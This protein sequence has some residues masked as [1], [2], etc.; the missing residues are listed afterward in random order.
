MDL[1]QLKTFLRMAQVKHIGLTADELYVSQSTVN[2]RIRALEEELGCELFARNGRGLQLTAKGDLFQKY[3]ERALEILEEGS[4]RIKREK[5]GFRGCL[6][7]GAVNAAAS[8]L[9]PG[10][11][12]SFRGEYPAVEVEVTTGSTSEI[13]DW[14]LNGKVELG[15]VR[16]P[17]QY[18]GVESVTILSEPILLIIP[19][20]HPWTCRKYATPADFQGQ[21]ILASNRASSIWLEIMNWFKTNDVIPHVGME[22]DHIE[23]AKQM[24]HYGY[25]IAFVPSTSVEKELAEGRVKTVSLKPPFSLCRDTILIRHRR[26]PL[27]DYAEYFWQYLKESRHHRKREGEEK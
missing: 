26:K 8:Y 17:L 14:V 15:L 1:E 10:F 5:A 21:T 4:Q 3:A 2:S 18:M 11:L 27:S 25:G 22:V 7:L 6:R 23:T 20:D 12:K 9:L 13:I 24:V 16:G 19:P